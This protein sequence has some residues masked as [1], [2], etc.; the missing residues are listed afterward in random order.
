[1]AGAS[2]A[3]VP[4][5]CGAADV[6]SSVNGRR[7]GAS[8]SSMRAWL[9]GL[10]WVWAAWAHAGELPCPPALSCERAWPVRPC[11]GRLL[12]PGGS[13]PE[14]VQVDVVAVGASP[15]S[16]L[17]GRL[18]PAE[19][20]ASLRAAW[21]SWVPTPLP[22]RDGGYS[23]WGSGL[24]RARSAAGSV[25]L[26]CAGGVAARGETFDL[27]LRPFSRHKFRVLDADSAEPL[28]AAVV[29]MDLATAEWHEAR[30]DVAGLA[31]LE[32]PLAHPLELLVVSED[33][34][35]FFAATAST[36]H[37]RRPLPDTVL[38]RARR[39]VDVRV[40]PPN[41][42]APVRVELDT[43][44]ARV[45]WAT[46][47]L[48]TFDDVEEHELVWVRASSGTWTATG[49]E[50]ETLTLRPTTVVTVLTD[51]EQEPALQALQL[52]WR[53]V[54]G[55][56]ATRLPQGEWVAEVDGAEVWLSVGAEP[57]RVVARPVSE[58]WRSVHQLDAAAPSRTIDG[59]DPAATSAWG[60]VLRGQ[61]LRPNGTPLR[62]FEV[63]GVA[64]HS[65]NGQFEQRYPT[66]LRWGG[67]V[68]HP[69]PRVTAQGYEDHVLMSPLEQVTLQP[70]RTV[71]GRVVDERGRPVAFAHVEAGLA[72]TETAADGSFSLQGPG[73]P[74]P[75][76]AWRGRRLGFGAPSPDVGVLKLQ[77]LVEAT[78]HTQPRARLRVR[79]GPQAF[80]LWADSAGRAVVWGVAGVTR[81]QAD[82]DACPQEL[83]AAGRWQPRCAERDAP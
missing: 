22:V 78:F 40:V 37:G 28:T 11:A 67:A 3:L 71:A 2:G 21:R 41:P 49:R 39:R 7:R 53:R 9:C 19:A 17:D 65:V 80:D 58:A 76:I 10:G 60:G 56:W 48:A 13:L 66:T 69:P 26:S 8:S 63:A 14:D 62:H 70:W 82:G 44:P 61:V 74:A 47:G 1:M 75:L 77:P 35:P 38:L 36:R 83:V 59:A 51:S 4:T 31:V 29:V 6:I 27:E 34:A 45:A 25:A 33:R 52:R 5:A 55:G 73:L 42:T 50:S 46:A 20:L 16:R 12:A 54:S 68:F 18:P 57:L 64:H 72:N 24:V 43:R 79:T 23:F 32:L 81:V 30:T 15:D